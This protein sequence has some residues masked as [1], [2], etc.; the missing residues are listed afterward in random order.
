MAKSKKG[1]N[2][3][4]EVVE[5]IFEKPKK[6][7][8]VIS[9]SVTD[10][11]CNYS[12]EHLTGFKIG[13]ITNHKKGKLIAHDDLHKALTRMN[14]HLAVID[15]IF[16]HAG[17]DV[18]NIDKMHSHDFTW[19]YSVTGFKIQGKDEN[20]GVILIGTKAVSGSGR[21]SLETH[22]IALDKS[23]SYKWYNELRE[24]VEHARYEVEQ[25][26]AGKGTL[27][28]AEEEEKVDPRQLNAFNDAGVTVEADDE[29][30]NAKV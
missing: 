16:K 25:Y 24:A 30:Q 2:V 21:F 6:P 29:F 19:L 22:K 1:L 11:Y 13:E 7:F 15:D 27:Q 23:S 28:E 9:A 18:T 14:V 17:I 4:A 5:A 10:G 3:S 20:E 26:N 8:Q 12:L